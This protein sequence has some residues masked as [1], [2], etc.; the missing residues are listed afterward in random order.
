MV[1]LLMKSKRNCRIASMLLTIWQGYEYLYYRIYTWDL[2]TFG[3]DNLPQFNAAI[4]VSFMSLLNLFTIAMPIASL[5]GVTGAFNINK[6]A[7]GGVAITWILINYHLL[8]RN[9]RYKKMALKFA[10]ESHYDRGRNSVL[11]WLYVIFSFVAAF[12]SIYYTN[13]LQ[14]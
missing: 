1:V 9:E 4:N 10:Q 12:F 14:S 8:A 6:Y 2:R 11:C 7:I 3:E 5:L 13:R